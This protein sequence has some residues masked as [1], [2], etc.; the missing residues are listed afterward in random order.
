MGRLFC[1]G[2]HRL[3]EGMCPPL[4]NE[5]TKKKDSKRMEVLDDE[6]TD[7]EVTME[8]EEETREEEK[9]ED[10]WTKEV[11]EEDEEISYPLTEIKP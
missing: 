4:Q 11:E 7:E 9:E 1:I 10:E 6:D 8:E 2:L 3:S 5:C